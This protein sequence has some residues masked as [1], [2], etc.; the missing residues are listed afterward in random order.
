M[1]AYFF[2]AL[3]KC[4]WLLLW[5]RQYFLDLLEVFWPRLASVWV[6]VLSASLV[7]STSTVKQNHFNTFDLLFNLH[8]ITIFVAKTQFP[9]SM[10]AKSRSRIYIFCI[11]QSLITMLTYL[12]PRPSKPPST[13]SSSVQK[14]QDSSISSP[15]SLFRFFGQGCWQ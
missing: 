9:A 11:L 2:I 15:R 1:P 12:Y 5:S 4:S 8:P 14:S 7:Q 10:A 3:K 6:K 13:P